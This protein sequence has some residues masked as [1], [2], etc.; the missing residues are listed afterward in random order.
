MSLRYAEIARGIIERIE[1]TQEANIRA[2]ADLFA[3]RIAA[4][5]LVHLFG[6][7][8]SRMGVEE[9]A[10]RIGTIAGFHPI[11]EL[12]LSYYTNVVGTMGLAQSLFLERMDGFGECLLN[13]YVF[14]AERDAAL[15]ISSTGINNVPV[16]VALGLKARGLTVVGITSVSHS[17]SVA[18]RHPSGQR[19]CQVADIVIDNC[20]PIGDAA[21]L[22]D[23]ADHPVAATSTLATVTIV[24]NINYL[25]A[26]G[27]VA[28]GVKPLVLGTPHGTDQEGAVAGLNA[29]YAEYR[30][31]TARTGA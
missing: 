15:V 30:R 2:A 8:H 20:T 18:S 27:L 1:Q 10:P 24:H 31:R 21:I 14:D 4:G 12:S 13:N 9:I 29:Y 6:A 16:E 7:G 5:G 11:V 25:L 17:M 28:R 19:L 22:V 26:E 23:G 3:D